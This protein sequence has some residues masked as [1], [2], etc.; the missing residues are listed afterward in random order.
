MSTWPIKTIN[1]KLKKYPN[2]LRQIADAPQELYCRGNL[3]LLDSP[4]FAVVGTRK[5]TSYG[6]EAAERLVSELANHFT[7]VS[8]LAYG[9]DA[10]AH[11]AALDADGKTIAVLGAGVNDECI[12]PP[13]NFN[14]AMEILK[15]DGLIVSEYPAGFHANP[16]TFPQRNRIISGLSKGVL[17]VEADFDSG[18][19]ITARCA[20]DQNRDVFAVPGS[21]FSSR[22]SGTNHIIQKGAKLVTS[23]NDILEE[24][25]KNLELFPKTSNDISTENDVEKKI[26][27][28]L[29]EK[30]ELSADE[31]VRTAGLETSTIAAALSLLELKS[32]IKKSGN[33][34]FRK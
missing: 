9:I 30:G 23:V 29:D 10:M 28:I 6:K 21:I 32:K 14:L 31:I 2:L 34:K 16:K 17:V 11:Q 25:G 3:E 13:S 4:C 5:L 8:G 15:N 24:Y 7:I 22:S 1:Q 33:G 20:L 12:G 19:L 18:S 26:L 27:D